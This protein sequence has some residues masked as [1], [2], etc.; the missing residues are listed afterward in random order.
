MSED[1][2]KAVWD[3]RLQVDYIGSYEELPDWLSREE[4]G[5]FLHESLKPYEDPYPLVLDGIDYALGGDP[6][7]GGFV[8]LG[9][10]GDSLRGAVVVLR[11]GMRGYVP[12]NLLLFIAVDPES[13]GKGIGGA[14]ISRV[15]EECEGQVKLHVEHDN[16]ARKLYERTGF[17]SKYLEMRWTRE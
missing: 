9:S 16:P 4:L 11:T 8:V 3:G 14:L 2:A 12:E 6:C 7:K 15:L 1:T 5:R 10:E 13:R 17:K